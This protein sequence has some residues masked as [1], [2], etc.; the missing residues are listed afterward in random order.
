MH[1]TLFNEVLES[2]EKLPLVQQETVLEII[3]N[4]IIEARRIDIAKNARETLK[5]FKSGKA[6]RGSAKDFRKAMTK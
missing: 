5:A 6:K 3:H 4:R 2:V 1:T